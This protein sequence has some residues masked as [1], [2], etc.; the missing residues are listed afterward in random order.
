MKKKV[1][2]YCKMLVLR[3]FTLIELLVV[4]AIIAILA[5]MLLPSLNM[6]RETAKSIACT[7]QLKQIGLA[8]VF[9]MG[10]NSEYLPMISGKGEWDDKLSGYLSKKTNIKKELIFECPSTNIGP[11]PNVPRRIS[12][13]PTVP[14]ISSSAIRPSGGWGVDSKDSNALKI[15]KSFKNVTKGSVLV[16]EMRLSA[17]QGGNRAIPRYYAADPGYTNNVAYWRAPFTSNNSK[18]GVRYRHNEKANFL[19]KDFH[20]KSYRGGTKFW[21]AT[22]TL[23]K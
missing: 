15:A 13:S 20:V 7:N 19:F 11:Y 14:N 10:D 5:A 22:W 9:Y 18:Y 8:T 1:V 23:I 6:A 12:Y 4:I 17:T 2:K 21:N 3:G 16:I